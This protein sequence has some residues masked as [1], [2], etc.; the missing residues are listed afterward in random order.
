MSLSLGVEGQ[1]SQGPYA[2]P[3]AALTADAAAACTLDTLIILLID[4]CDRGSVSVCG[5][6]AHER[7]SNGGGARAKSRRASS[8]ALSF[9]LH[10]LVVMEGV[11]RVG[12]LGVTTSTSGAPSVA[13]VIII[14]SSIS[15][16]Y[17]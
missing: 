16:D 5:R 8:P 1:I 3:I 15:Y 6:Q 11:G 9:V 14:I 7:H 17:C 4:R 10:L 2:L 12:I 13:A